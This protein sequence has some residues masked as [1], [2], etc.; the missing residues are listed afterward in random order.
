VRVRCAISHAE[1]KNF[2]R[3]FH[4]AAPAS[5]GGHCRPQRWRRPQH[6]ATACHSGAQQGEARQAAVWTGS[7]GWV[8]LRTAGFSGVEGLGTARR[9]KLGGELGGRLIPLWLIGSPETVA[10]RLLAEEVMPRLADLTG[11][12]SHCG[13]AIVVRTKNTQR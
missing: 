8:R 11:A 12:S 13:H 6:A 2:K 1:D 9:E 10:T 3:H 7:S 4:P 5:A